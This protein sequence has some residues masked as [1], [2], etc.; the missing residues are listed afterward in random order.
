[1]TREVTLHVSFPKFGRNY[2][3]QHVVARSHSSLISDN[4]FD[5]FLM[6]AASNHFSNEVIGL[7]DQFRFL[8]DILAS[9]LMDSETISPA[10]SRRREQQNR[11]VQ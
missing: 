2:Y 4:R 7:T 8:N 3:S 6:P 1:M 10:Q 9:H 5:A 11:R